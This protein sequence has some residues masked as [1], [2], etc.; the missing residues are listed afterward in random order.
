MGHEHKE[1]I[2]KENEKRTLIV[3]I[4]TVV[5]MFAEIIYGY[6]TH[7]MGLLADGWHM[8]THALALTL[9]YAAYVLIRKLSNSRYFPNGTDK[10][11]TLAAFTSSIFLGLT[12][13]WIIFEAFSRMIN[14]LQI[15][16]NEAIIVAVIGLLVNF[17][18]IFII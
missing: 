3:I 18:C 16:F 13:F 9:T 11:G 2:T 17:I 7:S 1:E 12:G 15:K 6:T 14:P 4:F 5:T 8:A 10:I